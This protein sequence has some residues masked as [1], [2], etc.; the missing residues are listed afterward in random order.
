MDLGAYV[1]IDDLSKIA[2]ANGIDI[3]RL[4]GYRLMSEEEP[5]TEEEIKVE[6]IESNRH[7]YE[8]LCE[9]VP[10]F[11]L[12]PI[13]YEYSRKTKA[14]MKK[15]LDENGDLRWD[16][17]HGKK[18]KNAKYAIKKQTNAVKKQYEIWNKYAGCADVLYVHARIGGGNWNSYKAVIENKPWFLE[19]VDDCFDSTYCDIYAK[20]NNKLGAENKG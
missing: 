2:E 1:Q 3:P 14:I 12:Y 7:L 17:I 5:W 10:R 6:I 8:S 11:S 20:I 18:R 15:Y 16:I 9:S 19:K 4:R 13:Y